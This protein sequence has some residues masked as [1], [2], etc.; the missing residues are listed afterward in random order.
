MN[1]TYETLSSVGNNEL[2]CRRYDIEAAWDGKT[3]DYRRV[4]RR[5]RLR[6][7]REPSTGK[8]YKP[9]VDADEGTNPEE[10]DFYCADCFLSPHYHGVLMEGE[11]SQP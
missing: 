7:C 11:K 4:H 6:L 1:P 10:S 9:C 2:Y 8:V 3:G 5:H